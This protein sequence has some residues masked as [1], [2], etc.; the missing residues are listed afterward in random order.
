M[1]VQARIVLYAPDEAVARK[2]ARAAF[3]RIAALEDVMS[4]YR[5]GSEVRR[6][7][8]QPAGTPVPVSADLF[9]VLERAVWLSRLSDGAFDVTVAP[10][11]QLW[12]TA[13]RSGRL[14]SEAARRAALARVGWRHVRLD[15]AARTVTLGRSGMQID[16]GGIAKGYAIDQALAVL[17]AHGVERALVELGGDMVVGAPPP[18][19][20]GWRI[21]VAYADEAHRWQ[22]LSHAAVS[23]SGDTEQFVE[24][25]GRRYSHV[26]DP[27]TGL[28]LTT[29]VAA[30]VVAPDAF[31]SDGLATMLTVLGREQGLS[32]V[33]AHF[34]E[35]EVY[36]RQ[37]DEVPAEATGD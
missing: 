12:R 13:R 30:T 23:T 22:I 33:R 31:T 8:V 35:V 7:C 15:A 28:G 24:I 17:Q 3:D 11:V 32:L 25:D 1:G 34:P 18:G 29:R 37:V 20:P 9:A 19:E 4:D 10:V 6:L 5:P 36:V 16:L 2:A 27:R 26:V 14:P 21:R